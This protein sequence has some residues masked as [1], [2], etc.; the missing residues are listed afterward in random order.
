MTDNLAAQ[1]LVAA[2]AI[3]TMSKTE[4]QVLLRRAAMQINNRP[5]PSRSAIL[6]QE[7]AEMADD[8]A[9]EHEMNRDEAVNTILINW[10]VDAGLLEIEDIKDDYEN[11]A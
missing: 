7:V 10:G 11:D 8:F 1:L 6:L 4:I 5:I 2:K 3:D 9:R